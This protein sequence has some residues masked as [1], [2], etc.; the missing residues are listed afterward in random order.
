[1]YTEPMIF[2][3]RKDL[4]PFPAPTFL[5]I[6]VKVD[7]GG[8]QEYKERNSELKQGTMGDKSE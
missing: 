2:W 6:Q 4:V 8:V 3:N 5:Y 1:M 7:L